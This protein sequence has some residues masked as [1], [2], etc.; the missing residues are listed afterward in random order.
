MLPVFTGLILIPVLVSGCVSGNDASKN[1]TAFIS[2]N[3][4]SGS[5]VVYEGAAMGFRGMIHVRVTMEQGIITEIDV[6]ESDEDRAV[7]GAAIDELMDLALMY[8]TTEI[9]AI[10]GATETSFG[11]LK[12]VE[13]AI[14][15]P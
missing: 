1:G 3:G 13:N 4:A 12:A 5:G 14:M 6:I 2:E 9:D 11:F 8:N 7:G 15:D 10:S